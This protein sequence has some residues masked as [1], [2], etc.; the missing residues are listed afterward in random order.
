MLPLLLVTVAGV[1]SAV[2]GLSLSH[3][4]PDVADQLGCTH[5]SRSHPQPGLSRTTCSYDG[6]RI[7]I[8]SFGT[9]TFSF[10]GDLGDYLVLGPSGTPWIIGCQRRDDCVDVQREVGGRLT[11]GPMPG[12]SLRNQ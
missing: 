2:V 1:I 4:P 3:Q 11:P 8:M 5:I 7:V 10:Y 6:D 12:L 9:G